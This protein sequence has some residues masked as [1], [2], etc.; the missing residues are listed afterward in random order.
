LCFP[1]KE[2]IKG[3]FKKAGAIAKNLLNIQ[4]DEKSG[5]REKCSK[6]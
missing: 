2:L 5:L 3:N 1:L 6:F 4:A